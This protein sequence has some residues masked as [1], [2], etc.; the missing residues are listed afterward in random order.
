[1]D[2]QHD[3]TRETERRGVRR[4]EE[5]VQPVSAGR[6]GLQLEIA[7]VDLVR[8]TGAIVTQITRVP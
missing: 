4:R 7:P 6:R 1:V 8:L 2:S 5:D 3:G